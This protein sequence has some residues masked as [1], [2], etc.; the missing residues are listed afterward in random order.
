[1]SAVQQLELPLGC[2]TIRYSMNVYGISCNTCCI[3][4][5]AD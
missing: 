1:M 2:T 3:M 5:L 4:V